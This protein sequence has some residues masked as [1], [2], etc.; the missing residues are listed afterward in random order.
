MQIGQGAT[1]KNKS[2]DCAS[3]SSGA[4]PSFNVPNKNKRNTKGMVLHKK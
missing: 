2:G 4:N 1:G 3:A